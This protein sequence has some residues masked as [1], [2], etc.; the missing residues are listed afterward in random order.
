ML[1]L[2]AAVAEQVAALDLELPQAL[3]LHQARSLVH[4]TLLS[5]VRRQALRPSLQ[6][7]C[8]HLLPQ[9]FNHPRLPVC[10]HLLRPARDLQIQRIETRPAQIN[11]RIQAA[12]NREE[13]HHSSEHASS[14]KVLNKAQWVAPARL[15]AALS[16][17]RKQEMNVYAAT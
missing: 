14:S 6:Q 8:N 12:R 1:K 5:Q 17:M 3:P 16:K 9:V 15:E 4:R 7:V 2:V 10:N 13:P 11:P